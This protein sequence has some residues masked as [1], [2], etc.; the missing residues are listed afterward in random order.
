[1]CW[2]I[3]FPPARVLREM[4]IFVRNH[5]KSYWGSW[6]RFASRRGGRTPECGWG[7]IEFREI[8]SGVV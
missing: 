4:T 6:A 8:V 1:M 2:H 3:V 5:R 7:R